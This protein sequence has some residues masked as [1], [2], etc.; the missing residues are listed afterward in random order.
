M[1]IPYDRLKTNYLLMKKI[2]AF[3]SL[4]AITIGLTAFTQNDKKQ[5]PPI[6]EI[7]A[8]APLQDY[9]MKNV[10]GKEYS[11]A[12]LKGDKGIL[13]IFS[14]NT[15]PFVVGSKDGSQG[16]EGRYNYTSDV[17]KRLG[18]GVVF[19]N[20][21]EAFRGNEDSFEAMQKRAKEKNY[22]F[23]YVVDKNH[24]LADAFGARTTPHVYLFNE[25]ME[26][27]YKGAIDD[28]NQSADN[29]KEFWLQNAMGNYVNG[30]E[31]SPNSTR[32]LG[33]SI[34]RVG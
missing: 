30:Q 24:K 26:L 6:L 29:V 15:C 12:S 14:S 19:V 8:K 13:V 5:A 11:L 27:I 17:A 32:Q 33:C 31:I 23:P 4:V 22:S 20:S 18:F 10:D 1:G 25:K 21:N 16:W 34:K 3:F 2:V 7:G 28:N 9:K